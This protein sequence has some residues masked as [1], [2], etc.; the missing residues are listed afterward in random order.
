MDFSPLLWDQDHRPVGFEGR[1]G[2]AFGGR[3]RWNLAA[4]AHAL[5]HPLGGSARF[6]AVQAGV[7]L[8]EGGRSSAEV[9]LAWLGFDR[10]Q[11]LAD[12]GLAR[13]NTLAAG[14][15]ANDYRL[16][17]LQMVWRHQFA[18][19]P[20]Q[21]RL[22]LVRN[23]GADTRRDGARASAVYGDRW[24]PGAWEIGFA[25]QRA[26]SDAVLAAASADDWWFR[27]GARGHMP[28]IGVA[29]GRNWSARAAVFL[30][31]RD[32]LDARTD[33]LLLDL[34]GRW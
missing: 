5:E 18:R 25:W 11:G 16:L 15:Y 28:W 26:Q 32:G 8:F 9:L 10:L 6:A 31:R 14:A 3:H 12:A 17:D 20:L 23:L 1:A 30:E 34:E 33:R 2:A 22:D 21:L 4:G 19:A 7:N 24:Q 29:L 13:G 27:A